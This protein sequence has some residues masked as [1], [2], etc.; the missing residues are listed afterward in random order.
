MNAAKTLLTSL[1]QAVVDVCF[2]KHGTSGM[3][4]SRHSTRLPVPRY[5][6]N[7]TEPHLIEAII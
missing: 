4:F 2:S 3:L 6:M 5:A 7:T 1:L